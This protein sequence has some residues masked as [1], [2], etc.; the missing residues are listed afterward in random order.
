MT[1]TERPD[2]P[3]DAIVRPGASASGIAVGRVRWYSISFLV[4]MAACLAEFLTGS[5]PFL[6][7]IVD[8]LGF[9]FNL[10]LYGGGALLIREAA[11]R[12]GKRWG[13]I[14]LLGGA[15]AVGEEGFAAKTM[16]DP[17]SPII[18]NQLYSHWAG[19]N[20]LPL[21]DLTVF[22]S[23]FSIAVPLL[24]VEL[25]FP[26]TKGRRLLGRTGTTATIAVYGITVLLLS[27]FLGDPFVP[28][29][30][31]V[32]FLAAYA[33]AFIA[34]AYLVPR[35]FLKAR[36]ERPD[37]RERSFVLLGL[38]FMGGFFLISGSLNT[39]WV[40]ERLL[41]WPVATALVLPLAG[42]TAWYLV[43]HAGWSENDVAKVDFLLGMSL[44]FV[45]IDALA[46][47][48]GDTGVLLFT[49]LVLAMLVL[50]RRR[51]RR[52][53]KVSPTLARPLVTAPHVDGMDRQREAQRT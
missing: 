23:A 26:E 19:V 44:A 29:L 38:G 48:G 51:A 21:V 2:L 10:G 40:V 45:P 4:V 20:W 25:V 14:L 53:G 12:W 50:L 7:P 16:I 1:G 49:G 18:G 5:T 35:S 8:P 46:E 17:I 6:G 30:Y 9:A 34:A 41:P 52:P 43:K 37:R 33:S 13:A 31:V 11:V 47:L 42:F 36:G 28:P 15:Y 27:L 39:E 22:H 3:T 32:A 24:L